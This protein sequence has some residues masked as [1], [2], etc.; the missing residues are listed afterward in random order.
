MRRGWIWTGSI[1]GALVALAI[2]ATFFIDEPLRRRVEYEMNQ[3]LRGYS[4][5]IGALNFHPLGFSIDFKNIVVTQDAYPDPP[6]ARVP[7][8]YASVQ[9]RELIRAKLVADFL[10]DRPV[11]YFDRRHRARGGDPAGQARLAG[12]AAGDVPGQD[13]PVQDPR[14]GRDLRGRAESAAAH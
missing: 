12:G 6:V 11:V 1:V 14:R 7:L 3:R 4:V 2:V 9:W 10:L 13:Q 8:L 5:R